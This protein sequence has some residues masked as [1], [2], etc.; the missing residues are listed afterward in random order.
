MSDTTTAICGADE[1]GATRPASFFQTPKP[2]TARWM[3]FVRGQNGEKNMTDPTDAA[4]DAI[5]RLIVESRRA[6]I[7][8]ADTLRAAI[9]AAI[10]CYRAIHG[11]A[12]AP[13]A[14]RMTDALAAAEVD[15]I[16]DLDARLIGPA[17]GTA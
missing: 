4:Y 13:Y 11:T 1:A 15:R 17:R 9:N 16:C 5:A 7:D 10:G 2:E 8:D 14:K 12:A 3:Q 6:G